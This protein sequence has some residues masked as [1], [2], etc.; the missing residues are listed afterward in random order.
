M[1]RLVEPGDDVPPELDQNILQHGKDPKG[2]FRGDGVRSHILLA[3]CTEENKAWENKITSRGEFTQALLNTLQKVGADKIS[4]ADL[5]HQMPELP[6][7]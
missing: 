5:I 2:S 3:A 7:E 1:A 4:Y 6:N